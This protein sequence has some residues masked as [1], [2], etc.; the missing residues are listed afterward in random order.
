MKR[1]RNTPISASILRS[2]DP[3]TQ[4]SQA[5]SG[6]VQG[7]CSSS[8]AASAQKRTETSDCRIQGHDVTSPLTLINAHSFLSESTFVPRDQIK[9]RNNV[10]TK[11]T[12]NQIEHDIT[13]NP[14]RF[15]P[16]GM[17]AWDRIVAVIVL[18]QDW[19]FQDWIPGF[20]APATLFE[21][22]LHWRC[23]TFAV[24]H[25]ARSTPSR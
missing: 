5:R 23:S 18:G 7:S 17:K 2:T 10:P 24:G 16:G 25:Q 14:T 19:Q 8:K 20:N 6:F 21:R 1:E 15:F 9:S 12:R 3:P 13:D 22:V 11:F 4:G